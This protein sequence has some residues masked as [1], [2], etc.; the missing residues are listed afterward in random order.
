MFGD[1]R[2]GEESDGVGGKRRGPRWK[3]VLAVGL[4]HVL[5]IAG[6][7]RAF[8]PDLVT[9]AMQTVTDAFTV[10]VT[11]P[12]P[13]PTPLPTPSPRATEAA[14]KAAAAGRKADPQPVSAPKVRVVVTKKPAAPVSG[15]GAQNAAGASDAGEGTGRQGSGIGT[16]AGG[17]GDGQGG[18]A[19][20]PPVKIAGDIN[21]ARDYPRDTRDLRIGDRVIVAL[22]VGV[23]GRVRACRVVRPSRDAAADRITCQ[24]AMER[25]RFRPATDAAGNA[26]EAVFGWQQKWFYNSSAATRH[27]ILVF[28]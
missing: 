9:R 12:P 20:S 15:K 21:S 3:V 17:Q 24:L 23:D 19:V 1:G 11:A 14:G 22:T 2:G 7:I 6:L 13:A 28:T 4:I 5:A 18:G 26:V 8:T 10:T 25:F 16:G 27:P